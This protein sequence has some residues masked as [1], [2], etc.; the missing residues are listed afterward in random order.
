MAA[1]RSGYLGS[2]ND[3]QGAALINMREKTKHLDYVRNHPEGD[4]YLLRFLRATM[5]S[6][7]TITSNKS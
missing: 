7:V 2:L 5:E 3:Q 6:K 4:A 1:P